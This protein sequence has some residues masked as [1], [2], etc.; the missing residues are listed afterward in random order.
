MSNYQRVY[1]LKAIVWMRKMMINVQS[2]P[3]QS[4]GG[5]GDSSKATS[6]WQPACNRAFESERGGGRPGVL[7]TSALQ[8]MVG[9][10]F[11]EVH[12]LI[13]SNASI[14][15]SILP[16]FHPSI[17]PDIHTSIHGFYSINNVCIHDDME[18]VVATVNEQIC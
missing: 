5:A 18:I 6:L 8:E 3:C 7:P 1:K 13:Y 4:L 11:N 17:H 9:F 10:A 14:H 16:S 12:C 15:P 2:S